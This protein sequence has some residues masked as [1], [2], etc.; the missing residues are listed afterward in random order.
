MVFRSRT[1][2]A[3]AILT[4]APV[5]LMGA[6]GGCIAGSTF[7]KKGDATVPVAGASDAAVL[8]QCSSFS[9]YQSN[10]EAIVQRTCVACHAPGG[11]GATKFQ[12]VR[13]DATNST[14]AGTNYGASKVEAM[15]SGVTVD[16]NDPD[17][18][19]PYLERLNGGLSHDISLGVISDDYASVRTWVTTE[20]S[21]PCVIDPTSGQIIS[22]GL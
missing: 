11:K 17:G 22:G 20:L 2:L 21:N 6:Q 7:S 12:L 14:I 8:I 13:G 10:V 5:F 4:L 3:S 19:S 16:P 1:L 18:T 15:P 9:A